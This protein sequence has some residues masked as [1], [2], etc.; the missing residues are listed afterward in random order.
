[1]PAPEQAGAAAAGAADA[2][3]T[4]PAC[5]PQPAAA[6]AQAARANGSGAAGHSA[7]A[8]DAVDALRDNGAS[9]G[10]RDHGGGPGGGDAGGGGGF[11]ESLLESSYERPTPGAGELRHGTEGWRSLETSFWVPPCLLLEVNLSLFFKFLWRDILASC[12]TAPMAGAAWRHPSG[13]RPCLLLHFES[14]WHAVKVRCLGAAPSLPYAS[15]E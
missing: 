5:V 3:G 8:T 10:T 1:M 13:C 2:P 14:F 6:H 15:V 12:G 9:G 4:G 7:Q 11:L